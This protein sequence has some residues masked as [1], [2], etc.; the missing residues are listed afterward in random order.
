[1]NSSKICRISYF[2]ITQHLIK[3]P[4]Y[5]IECS[6]FQVK[7]VDNDRG[8]NGNISYSVVTSPLQVK[9]FEVDPLTGR[10][11]TAIRFDREALRGDNSVPVTVKA[12]D[13]G[14]PQ[15][16][17]SHCTFW[18]HIGDL[19]D[20]SPVFDSPSYSTSISESTASIGRRVFAV[21]ATDQD[22]GENA[23]IVYTLVD[24]PGDFFEIEPDTGIIYLHKSLAGVSQ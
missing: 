2:S 5:I 6:I 15:S 18:V 17:D 23:N 12:A 10:L 8:A 22:S 14:T 7:A 9:Q 16:L 4:C 19:N 13:Q 3:T 11:V 24:N 20:N 1:M 21:R